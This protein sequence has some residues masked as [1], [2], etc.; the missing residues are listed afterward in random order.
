VALAGCGESVTVVFVD[1]Q[2]SDIA[3]ANTK[4]LK[5]RV[6]DL[7]VETFDL[8]ALGEDLPTSFTLTPDVIEP[9]R[10]ELSGMDGNNLRARGAATVNV[11]EGALT[12]TSIVLTPSA[13]VQNPD[14]YYAMTLS[15][16]EGLGDNQIASDGDTY[17]VVFAGKT[18]GCEAGT[19]SCVV[20]VQLFDALGDP[21]TKT[22]A[23]AGALEV[24]GG[25]GI[26]DPA[27]AEANGLFAIA[28]LSPTGVRAAFYNSEWNEVAKVDVSTGGVGHL[29]PAVAGLANGQFV[30][31]WSEKADADSPT[32][33]YGRRFEVTGAPV[34]VPFA[35]STLAQARKPAVVATGADAAFVVVWDR[36]FAGDATLYMRPYD[37]APGNEIP[38]ETYDGGVISASS[39]LSSSPGT[40]TIAW[41]L[42]G[43]D[44]DPGYRFAKYMLDGISVVDEDTIEPRGTNLGRPSLTQIDEN[45][46][47]VAW[48]NCDGDE[49]TEKWGDGAGCGVFYQRFNESNLDAIGERLQ[50][51][52]L[53]DDEQSEPSILSVPGN[54]LVLGWTQSRDATSDVR[55]RFA[56]LELPD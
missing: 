37:P 39:V 27:I 41:N 31:V 40:V 53:P 33:V 45:E 28:Y 38:L 10:I 4:V 8:V 14:G 2:A 13:S 23:P 54:P 7:D 12:N 9:L 32:Q 51:S 44:V 15:G 29:G 30:V 43:P 20:A 16:T 47:A 34:A 17:A 42:G 19:P 50:G 5:V 6:N 36:Q 24:E 18:A 48:P 25:L 49:P 52:D 46:I 56:D 3:A 11:T 21:V 35:V 55:I 1:V 26:P 22:G